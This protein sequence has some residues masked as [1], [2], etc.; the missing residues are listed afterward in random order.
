MDMQRRFQLNIDKQ[1][2]LRKW[3]DKILVMILLFAGMIFAGF[4]AFGQLYREHGN[5]FFPQINS[6]GNVM[7]WSFTFVL[8]GL[9]L[10]L[11]VLGLQKVSNYTQ[12]SQPMTTSNVYRI[13]NWLFERQWRLV[14]LML[15]VWL[16]LYIPMYS[17]SARG[18]YVHMLQEV[19]NTKDAL[20][21]PW[22]IYPI[23][24][25]SVEGAKTY[26]S[27]Q[28][29]VFLVLL[30]GYTELISAKLTGGFLAGFV[31]LTWSQFALMLFALSYTLKNIAQH[32]RSNGLKLAVLLV[33]LFNIMIPIYATTLS[34]NP[35]FSIGLLLWIGVSVVWYMNDRRSWREIVLYVVSLIIMINSVKWGW[36]LLFITGIV[37]LF[38]YRTRKLGTISLGIGV[39]FKIILAILFATH[40]VIADDPIERN[41][42]QIQQMALLLKVQP[43]ALTATQKRQLSQ[44]FNLE[45][46][47]KN[48]NPV[49]SDPV[50]SSSF[51]KLK[52]SDEFSYTKLTDNTRYLNDSSLIA[53]NVSYKW[54][55]AKASDWHT[56][57]K[58]WLEM[59]VKHPGVFAQAFIL[60]EYQYFDLF[61]TNWRNDSLV[62]IHRP[63]DANFFGKEGQHAAILKM[64]TQNLD[65]DVPFKQWRVWL[66]NIVAS[67]QGVLSVFAR[68]SIAVVLSI[69]GIIT[70]LLRDKNPILFAIAGA[71]LVETLALIVA[72]VAGYSRYTMGFVFALPV[73][74]LL[75]GLNF[76]RETVK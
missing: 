14:V 42:V 24:Y 28:H 12:V 73:V 65:E 51:Q 66:Q 1:G 54:R 41:T 23:S 34:K 15:I 17:G 56:F 3:T 33:T 55:T 57:T 30:Y 8:V 70:M 35:T 74:V 18:D 36:L 67:K 59:L 7:I 11:I 75:L 32:V 6:F 16:P 52:H 46:M 45:A 60:K 25:Q 26:L 39:S 9:F 50:K 4:S 72:P 40:L 58:I 38:N 71:M 37:F 29:N 69:L 63:Y 47:A 49:I 20:Y 44:L 53:S 13:V 19:L 21:Q 43:D 48:Y 27:N 5:Q 76:R 2:W 62:Q 10:I 22:D 68:G 64:K 61:S 31:W